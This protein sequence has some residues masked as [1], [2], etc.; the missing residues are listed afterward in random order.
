MSF[1]VESYVIFLPFFGEKFS[2]L[3]TH[4]ERFKPKMVYR[5]IP[6]MLPLSAHVLPPIPLHRSSIVPSPPDYYR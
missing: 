2:A 5:W 4:V 1:S 3:S 6:L